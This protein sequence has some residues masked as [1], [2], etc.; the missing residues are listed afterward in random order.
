MFI[1]ESV[2]EINDTPKPFNE[3]VFE[4]RFSSRSLVFPHFH[5]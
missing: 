2:R 1:E 3:L 5:V 4:C